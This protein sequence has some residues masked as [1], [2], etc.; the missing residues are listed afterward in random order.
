M[1]AGTVAKRL[2][3]GVVV[4]FVGLL[5]V[6][7]LASIGLLAYDVGQ[8]RV[9]PATNFRQATYDSLIGWVGVPNLAIADNFGPGIPLHTN[10]EGMRIHHPDPATLGSGQQRIICSGDSFTYGSGV[11]D[12]ETYCAYLEQ[13]LPNTTTLNMAQR[14]F[15]IDQMYLWYER[16]AVR[17]PH[18]FQVLGFIWHDFERMG[19]TD[20]LGYAKPIMHLRDG[21]LVTENVPVPQW[22]AKVSR[23]SLATRALGD[24]RLMQFL[25]GRFAPSENERYARTNAQVLDVATA[26]FARLDS[27]N[28]Q[29]GSQLVL[30]YLPSLVDVA[31]STLDERRARVAEFSRRANIPF[32]DLTPGIR[33]MQPDTL[34][35]MFITPNGIPVDGASGHY[36]AAGNRWVAARIAERIR[37]LRGGG[38]TVAAAPAGEG[39]K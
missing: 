32:V 10:G 25:K 39:A 12:A 1:S 37:S 35:W 16:D 19:L 34:D 14:G 9:P 26:V 36:T 15:G 29:R 38:G 7:G 5:V 30:V 17:H 28:K 11:G 3:V 13:E 23:M 4:A 2:V 22:S 8:I 18:Q 33:A 20:Y 21:R 27:L 6:E 31:P 24:V